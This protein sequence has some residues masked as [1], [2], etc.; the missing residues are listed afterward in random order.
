MRVIKNKLDESIQ[1]KRQKCFIKYDERN[2]SKHYFSMTANVSNPIKNKDTN[3]FQ[4]Q[5]PVICYL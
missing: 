1:K 3:W 5:N 4:S 2:K